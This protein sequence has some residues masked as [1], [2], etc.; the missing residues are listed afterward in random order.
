MGS[1]KKGWD[2]MGKFYLYSRVSTDRQ[3]QHGHSL[4]AQQMT[5]SAWVQSYVLRFPE[6]AQHEQQHFVEDGES[7]FKKPF[8]T[9]LKGRVIFES[10]KRGDIVVC[11]KMDRAFRSTKD[12][13]LT[14]E[15]LDQRGVRVIMLDFP[16]GDGPLGNMIRTVLAAIAEF[17][18]S[19]RS[20]RVKAGLAAKRI[21]VNKPKDDPRSPIR[22]TV[23]GKGVRK[24]R[25]D[26]HWA[27]TQALILRADKHS[28]ETIS[29]A[30]E[31][32]ICQREGRP[33]KRSA[34]V[35]PVYGRE[36]LRRFFRQYKE[37][38][39]D[40]LLQ[41]MTQDL[42]L[43]RFIAGWNCLKSAAVSTPPS[44]KQR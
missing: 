10:A 3:A 34:F 1:T 9:R 28:E 41:G 15:A 14:C 36:F 42:L 6:L 35:K 24:H 20:E 21:S 25:T 38:A 18:S 2:L 43:D 40:P 23:P 8:R 5:L 44:G 27:L 31:Q 37:L 19:L 29:W 16:D 26:L 13:L 33:F 12:M 4:K 11:M 39:D 7:A 30:L 22:G 17:E 32:S